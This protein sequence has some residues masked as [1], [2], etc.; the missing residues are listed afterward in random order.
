M[1]NRLPKLKKK[2]QFFSQR[3]LIKWHPCTIDRTLTSQHGAVR[4]PF[5]PFSHF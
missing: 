5:V 4:W 2:Q 3:P 1:K